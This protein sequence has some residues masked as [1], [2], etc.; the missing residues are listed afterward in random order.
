MKADQINYLKNSFKIREKLGKLIL[1]SLYIAFFR[2]IVSSAVNKV[3][4]LQCISRN[5]ERI[6]KNL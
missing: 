5:Y 4:L 2:G 1:S 3:H 6:P